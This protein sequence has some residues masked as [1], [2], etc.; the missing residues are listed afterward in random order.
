M[1]LLQAHSLSALAVL[2]LASMSHGLGIN[3]RGSA[4]CS[5]SDSYTAENLRS[6]IGGVPDDKYFPKGKHIACDRGGVTWV[7][8]PG[9][10]ATGGGICAFVQ[11]I[12]GML[13]KDLKRL[14][15]FIVDHG[16]NVCG[17]VPTDYPDSNNVKDGQLTFNY[18]SSPDCEEGICDD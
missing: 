5:S 7:P 6:S 9:V 15:G 2:G 18:V 3:C 10:P 17:S 16:C 4:L 11:N 1:H 13:G 8:I 12:D 14:A